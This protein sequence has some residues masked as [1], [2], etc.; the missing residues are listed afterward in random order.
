MEISFFIFLSFSRNY[1]AHVFL[2]LFPSSLNL[3]IDLIFH[4]YSLLYFYTSGVFF[5]FEKEN[6]EN[7]R[8][9]RRREKE[10]EE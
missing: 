10:E 3:R 1:Q 6:S 4:D 7:K 9:R 8:R 5:T 2:L